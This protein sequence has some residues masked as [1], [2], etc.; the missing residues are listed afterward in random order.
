MAVPGSARA[1][2]SAGGQAAPIR[3]AAVSDCAKDPR[4]AEWCGPWWY[5]T[6]DGKRHRLSGVGR[7]AGAVAVSGDGRRL[8]YIRAKDARLVIRDLDGR[9]RVSRAEAWPSKLE[10]DV[11]RVTLSYDGSRVAVDCCAAGHTEHPARVYDGGTGALLGKVPGVFAYED[12]LSFSGDS[13]Q[14]LVRTDDEKSGKLSVHD[15]NG[16]RTTTVV[17]PRLIGD[18]AATAALNADGHTVAV[19]VIGPKPQLALYDLDSEL[20]TATYPLPASGQKVTRDPV[21]NTLTE[22]G[23]AVELVWT[24]DATLRMVRKIGFKRMRVQVYGIDVATGSVRPERAYTITATT[25]EAV[26]GR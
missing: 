12:A 3:Y 9:T 15:P 6:T 23:T 4:N 18:N 22:A 7:W 14:V 20:I 13:D 10:L 21:E 5:R 2:V 24:G 19:Y 11:T 8:A 1:A 26:S 16:E 17:P 25:E